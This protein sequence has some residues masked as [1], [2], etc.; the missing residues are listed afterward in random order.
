M[1]IRNRNLAYSISFFI[2]FQA[3]IPDETTD[4]LTEHGGERVIGH[5]LRWYFVRLRFSSYAERK[6]QMSVIH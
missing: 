2:E 3:S 6:A 5:C 4:N 1:L